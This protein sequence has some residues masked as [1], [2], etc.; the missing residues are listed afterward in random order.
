MHLLHYFRRISRNW[1]GI[2]LFGY[3]FCALAA[4]IAYDVIGR[5]LAI[6]PLAIGVVLLGIAFVM[7]MQSIVLLPE[8]E[9]N[10]AVLLILIYWAIL[11]A[12]PAIRLALSH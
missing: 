5:Y 9:T 3:G 12:V 2:S 1:L 11:L 6:F 4:L 7:S 10:K 8:P